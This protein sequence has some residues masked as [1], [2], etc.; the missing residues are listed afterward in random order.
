MIGYQ[1]KGGFMA[2]VTMRKWQEVQQ[3]NKL[4][5]TIMTFD[6]RIT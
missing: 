3:E 1:V 4:L 2:T 5:K 6:V